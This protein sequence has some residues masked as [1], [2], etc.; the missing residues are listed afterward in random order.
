[1]SEDIKIQSSIKLDLLSFVS[2]ELKTPLSTLKLNVDMLKQNTPE[3]NKRLIKIMEEEINWMIQFISDTLDLKTTENNIKINLTPYDW[4][5]WFQ[6]IHKHIE[7]K[8]RFFNRTLVVHYSHLKATVYIDPLYIQQAILQLVMNAI[9]FSPEKSKIEISW[10]LCSD[11][12]L[13]INIIDE[14]SGLSTEDEKQVFK[15]F[16]KGRE[17]KPSLLKGSGLGLTIVEK[18]AKA[19]GGQVKA[20]NRTDSKGSVFT[21]TL[22][23]NETS[24]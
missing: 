11:N 13:H 20:K 24:K 1:M 3:Q 8:T 6:S 18:I 19:H 7:Q 9:E 2:H 12:K 23:N 15:A 22:N 4:E 14:G 10:S 5:K 17:K 21:L 16:Y